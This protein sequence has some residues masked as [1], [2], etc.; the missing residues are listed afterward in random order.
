MNRRKFLG[1]STLTVISTSV[2]SLSFLTENL[3]KKRVKIPFASLNYLAQFESF[4]EIEKILTKY[5]SYEIIVA[6]NAHQYQQLIKNQHNHLLLNLNSTYGRWANFKVQDLHLALEKNPLSLEHLFVETTGQAGKDLS[7]TS[8]LQVVSK[9]SKS[10]EN[11]FVVRDACPHFY[12]SLKLKRYKNVSY[13]IDETTRSP[14]SL[15]L[16]PANRVHINDKD[17]ASFERWQTQLQKDLNSYESQ[18]L[19]RIGAT[20]EIRSFLEILE[21]SKKTTA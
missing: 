2:P 20:A 4:V 10:I 17:F 12:N 19:K 5:E 8:P 1:L 6:Q 21:L 3:E 18:A 7:L 14:I 13:F 16:S 9:V 15:V 11:S